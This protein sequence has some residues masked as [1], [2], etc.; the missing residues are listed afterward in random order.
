LDE[1]SKSHFDVH[2]EDGGKEYV[3][4]VRPFEIKIKSVE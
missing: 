3:Q 4:Q 2:Q 1:K